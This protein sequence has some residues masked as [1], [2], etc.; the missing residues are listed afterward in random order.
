MNKSFMQ[1]GF[2]IV[3]CSRVDLITELRDKIYKIISRVYGLNDPHSESGLNNFHKHTS[4]LSL[5]VSR[6]A[7]VLC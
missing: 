6:S 7:V 2:E 3:D 5:A 1:S 4:K